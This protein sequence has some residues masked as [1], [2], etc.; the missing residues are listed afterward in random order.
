LKGYSVKD[1]TPGI[2]SGSVVAERKVTDVFCLMIFGV[3]L[4]AMITATSLGFKYGDVE[5]FLAPIDQNMMICG[6]ETLG[7][8]S[9][10][11]FK[12][13]YITNIASKDPFN[14]GWC[15]KSCPKTKEDLPDFMTIAGK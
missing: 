9:A 10:V 8:K 7:D 5:K 15:V 12:K 4:V 1:S 11:D 6:H 3:F 2:G 14:S 13:L